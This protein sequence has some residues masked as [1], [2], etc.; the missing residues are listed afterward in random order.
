MAAVGGRYLLGTEW[1]ARGKHAS[2]YFNDEKDVI[3]RFN[4]LREEWQFIR[5]AGATTKQGTIL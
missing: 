5:N 4:Q 2:S 1:I 3:I